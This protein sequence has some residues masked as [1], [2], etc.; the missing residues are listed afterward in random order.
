MRCVDYCAERKENRLKLCDNNTYNFEDI[1]NFY[2]CRDS[3]SA[4]FTNT[5]ITCPYEKAS[6]ISVD[7]NGDIS[8]VSLND[9]ILDIRTEFEKHLTFTTVHVKFIKYQE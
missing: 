3:C 8:Y 5:N 6:V 4:I 7:N 1:S 2:E 9:I